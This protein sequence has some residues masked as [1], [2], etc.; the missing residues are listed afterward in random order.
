MQHT[1][2]LYKKRDYNASLESAS[3]SISLSKESLYYDHLPCLFLYQSRSFR[4]L[5]QYN[6]GKKSALS[7]IYWVDKTNNV[8]E[9]GDIYIE[10]ARNYKS[11]YQYDSAINHYKTAIYHLENK[12]DTIGLSIALN[13]LGAIHKIQ[14]NYSKALKYYT[15]DLEINTEQDYKKDMIIA[16]NNIGQ[17]HFNTK[18]FN[19]A[20]SFYERAESIAEEID[21]PRGIASANSNIGAIYHQLKE[22]DQALEKFYIALSLYKKQNNSYR[23]CETYL[24]ISNVLIMKE[25]YSVALSFI[26][27]SQ[28]LS[29]EIKNHHILNKSYYIEGECYYN[30]GKYDQAIVLLKKAEQFYNEDHYTIEYRNI[31]K[32]LHQSYIEKKNYKKAYHYLDKWLVVN[33]KINDL[34]QK[35]IIEDI[36]SKFENKQQLLLIDQLNKQKE[37][38]EEKIIYQNRINLFLIMI[39]LLLLAFLVF[40]YLINRKGRKT[41]KLIREQN[42]EILTIHSE[43]MDSLKLASKI[44]RSIVEIPRDTK[45]ALP[46]HFIFWKPLQEVSGDIYHIEKKDDYIFITLMDCT[47][48]GAPASLLATLGVKT[49]SDIIDEGHVHPDEILEE[50]DQRIDVES[51]LNKDISGMDVS[52]L[53]YDILAKTISFA[54]AKRPLYFINENEPVYIKGTRRSIGETLFTPKKPFE[55][56]TFNITSDIKLYMYSDGFGD[57]FGGI[58]NK[59]YLEKNLR[60]FLFEHSHLPFEVQ[61]DLLRKEYINWISP[62][63]GISHKSIDDTLV[64][65]FNFTV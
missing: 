56:H 46:E 51:S 52:I 22:A 36:N 20:I 5:K 8:D 38:K 16:L 26:K 63:E 19:K 30:M 33:E 11:L 45:Q 49:L 40:I 65:G 4:R 35:K 57:Q 23:I 24:N 10:L 64:I 34:E 17:V 44:Q 54:G 47:G 55:R 21:Y 43:L 3:N 25:E 62:S 39:S 32:H 28:E 14:G 59:K 61:K 6:E 58:H 13:N 27:K 60:K 9:V 37:L 1:K 53:V 41:Y 15:K 29:K 31:L 48:H 2:D 18:S 50:L 12:Q 42:H 7:A